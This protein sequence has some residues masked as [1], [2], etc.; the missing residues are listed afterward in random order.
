MFTLYCRWNMY[1]H[2]HVYIHIIHMLAVLFY[3]GHRSAV[4]A[5]FIT[6]SQ[7]WK[8]HQSHTGMYSRCT[9]SINVV[10]VYMYTKLQYEVKA[11]VW[12]VYYTEEYGGG[13]GGGCSTN[14]AT[15]VARLTESNP[16]MLH[17]YIGNERQL[18]LINRWT[19]TWRWQGY[20]NYQWSKPIS[21][22]S[23]LHEG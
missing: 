20:W 14:W 15:E 1:I 11:A 6:F 3:T 22:P 13:G 17:M 21:K 7:S 9:C 5:N 8:W 2:V 12:T 16:K 10:H 18:S 19:L 23:G 4:F